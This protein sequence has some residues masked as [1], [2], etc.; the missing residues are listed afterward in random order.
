[1]I[2]LDLKEQKWCEHLEAKRGKNFPH[3][4]D[5][6]SLESIKETFVWIEETFGA[7]QILVNNAGVAF[8]VSFT[9]EEK[10]VDE[11][12]KKIIDTNFAGLVYVSR[13]AIR[14][15]KKSEDFGMIVNMSALLGHK[16]PVVPFSYN[17][18]VHEIRSHC[19][20]RGVE[21]RAGGHKMHKSSRV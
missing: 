20:F 21:A 16:I 19:F 12:L 8:N 15:M 10:N 9:N 11:K 13:A 14:L 3:K 17:V 6:S 2:T 18:S 1:M 7:I 5:V 4:C